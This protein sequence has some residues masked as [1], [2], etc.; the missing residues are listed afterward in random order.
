ML[1]SPFEKNVTQGKADLWESGESYANDT[2]MSKDAEKHT[3]TFDYPLTTVTLAAFVAVWGVCVELKCLYLQLF[4]LAALSTE[5]DGFL[6][7]IF[8][9]CT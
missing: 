8:L 4:L 2:W 9:S 3:S 5:S 6:F 7:V 1:S